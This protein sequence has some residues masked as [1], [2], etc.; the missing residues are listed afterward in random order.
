MTLSDLLVS[1]NEVRPDEL[2]T[3]DSNL[4]DLF[5]LVDTSSYTDSP[6]SSTDQTSTPDK[7]KQS[8]Y[9]SDY[10][11]GK[12]LY[13]MTPV[14][15]EPTVKSNTKS[16]NNIQDVQSSEAPPLKGN[17]VERAKYWMNQF[18]RFGINS[19]Q[20]LALVSTMLGECGLNPKGS[21]NRK[22]LEGKGNTKKGWAHA[23]EG[24]VGFTHWS[25]KKRLIEQY[26]K[27]PRRKGP[28][29]TTSESE[30][31]KSTTR[32][33]SDLEN[34]DHALMTYL[35]YKDRLNAT[36]NYDFNNLIGDFYLEKAG[37]GFGNRKGAGSTPYEKALFTG[38]IYQ[39]SHKKLGY[40][41]A[42]KV[43]T[44]ERTLDQARSLATQLGIS[45]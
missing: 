43:N 38:K 27:D 11:G 45:V 4:P 31:E 5:S 30:Y 35:F 34:E 14:Q 42:A 17:V 16:T 26:N 13:G 9:F 41:K 37:R 39:E 33:I 10:A 15:N 32:H 44:F 2:S 3:I 18:S 24:A 12:S 23:G 28:K 7:Q 6:T 19:V 8:W 40:L 21:V 29:L 36:K 20:S 25:L 1:Y 22:E